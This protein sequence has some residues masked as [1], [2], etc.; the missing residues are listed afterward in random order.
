LLSYTKAVECK[1]ERS[2][3][4][5]GKFGPKGTKQTATSSQ[6]IIIYSFIDDYI[7]N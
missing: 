3:G 7:E 5:A 4:S 2:K 6:V 1:S